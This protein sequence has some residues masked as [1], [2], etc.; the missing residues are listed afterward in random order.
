[1]SVAATRVLILGARGQVARSLAEILP[2]HGFDVSV[3]ARP[4]MDLALPHTL[5]PAVARARPQVVVNAAAYTAVD[6]AE[7]EADIAMAVNAIG[8]GIAAG[9]ARAAGAAIIH[10]STDYVFDGSKSEPYEESDHTSPLG[11]YGRSKLAGEIAVAAANPRHLILRTSWVCAPH[12]ANFLQTMLRLAAEGPEVRVVDDQRGA[13]TFAADIAEAVARIIAACTP[14]S[15]GDERF[16]TFHLASDG[17]TSW[18]GFARA[19]MAGSAARGGP[20]AA[21][22]AIATRDYPTRVRRPAYSKLS[23]AKLARVYG[24]SLPHWRDGLSR[25]LDARVGPAQPPWA[26]SEKERP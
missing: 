1:M 16:G 21:V 11:V 25:C 4:E 9:S 13:P 3:A 17:E 8:A 7:D 12:G 10:F 14:R 5:S 6:R 24:L 22:A 26:R 19:I 20:S 15:D 18:C 23:T 2:R